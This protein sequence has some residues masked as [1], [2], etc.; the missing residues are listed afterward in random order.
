MHAAQLPEL[1]I[2]AS[3]DAE[4]LMS[5]LKRPKSMKKLILL[6]NLFVVELGNYFAQERI[7]EVETATVHETSTN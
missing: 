7:K 2:D 6:E 1:M 4:A 3:A 5:S